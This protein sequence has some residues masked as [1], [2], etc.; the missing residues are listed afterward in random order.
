MDDTPESPFFNFGLGLGLEFS[1]TLP[2][3]IYPFVRTKK[4]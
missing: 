1:W 4:L 2:F 3:P